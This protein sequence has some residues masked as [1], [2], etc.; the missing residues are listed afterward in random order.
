MSHP[1]RRPPLLARALLHVRLPGNLYDVFAG[2]LEERFQRDVGSDAAGARRAYWKDVLSPSISR[3]VRESRGMHLPPGASPRA[4]RG[5]GAVSAILADLKFAVRTLSKAPAFTAV[6]VL[7]LGLGIGPNTAIFSLVDAILFQDWGVDDPERIVD[8]YT[9]TRAGEYFYSGYRTFEIVE[10]GTGDVFESVAQHSLITARVEAPS[11]DAELVLG[12]MVSGNYFDVM[13]VRTSIGRTFLPEEDATEGTHPV[14]VLG[15]HYWQTRYGADPSIVGS[16]I[17]MNGRPY[18]VIGIAPETFKGRLAPGIGTDFW[19]PF[20][21]FP[22]LSPSKMGNG[23][24]TITGRLRAGVEPGQ[25]IAAVETI[26]TR[27]AERRRTEIENYRGYFALVAVSLADVKLHP[28]FDGIL[29]QMALLLF[30][31][32]GLVLLVACVNLA[33]FL[34][35]RASDRR[36]EMA[37]R[38]AMGAG[39]TAIVRQLLVESLVLSGLGAMLGLVLGQLAMRAIVSIELPVPIPL[40]L[41]VGLSLPL[42]LFTAG[43]AIVAAVLFGLTPAL[44]ATRAPV[45]ATLRDE[46]GSSGGKRKVGARGL[47][48]AGQMALSTVLLFGA[49][50][51]VRSLQAASDMDVGFATREAAVVKIETEANEYSLD[52]RI[53]FVEELGRRLESHSTVT[54]FGITARMPLDLGVI[55]TAFDI[56]GVEPPAD[57]SRHVLEMATITPGYFE[58]MGIP[59][60]EGRAFTDTDRDGSAPVAIL[61]KA[62]ADLYWPGESAIG[63]TLLRE[64]DGS[65]ALTVVGVAGNV[66]IWSLGESPRPYM[67]RPYFQGLSF[68]AFFVTA[69]GNAPPGELAALIRN[70]ARAIDPEVFLT[71]VGTMDDHLGY[72]YFLPRMAAAMLSI[73][74]VLALLLACMGLY[75]MVSYGVSRRTREMG[76][77]LALGAERQEVVNMVLKSGLVIV[78]VGAAVGIV[79]SLGLGQVVQRFLFGAGALDPLAILTAPLLLGVVAAVAT[80]LPARRASRVDPVRALRSE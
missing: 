32:V 15:N 60:L 26:A 39:R 24:L 71:E 67:Y 2:D 3:L 78:G 43:S 65:D 77:R 76:I 19:V 22:H 33:G 69:R 55:N 47:L 28:T 50:I 52:Q 27:E 74:G 9:L 20:Q 75:G 49:V 25:A 36:K 7:S 57:Q 41:E 21:M 30:A 58:T 17:R 23:D 37:V 10:D 64:P 29:T 38:V 80:Y 4:G 48:V 35:S 6:A 40:E 73:V 14:L 59:I 8:I 68:A 46:A 51:F 72:I 44:E 70:E 53:A 45:A 61:S 1:S 16:E 34:L 56:P 54:D 5:D 62:A 11:G 42:L 63:R 79:A 66:N 13:G 18:T 12:E 31:A